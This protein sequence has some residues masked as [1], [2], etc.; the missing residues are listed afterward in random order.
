MHNN[1]LDD[2]L[3]LS[4]WE[5]LPLAELHYRSIVL[6]FLFSSLLFDM[7]EYIQFAYW[8]HCEEN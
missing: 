1:D 2:D 8:P 3:T 5:K 6:Y 4:E 7:T